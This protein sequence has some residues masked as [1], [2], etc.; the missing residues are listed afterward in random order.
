MAGRRLPPEMVQAVL[1][2]LAAGMNPE[3][4]RC[5]GGGIEFAYIRAGPGVA[6]RVEHLP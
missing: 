4:G 3:P 1:G 5:G 2:F 6:G